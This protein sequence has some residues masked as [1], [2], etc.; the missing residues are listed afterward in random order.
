M[1]NCRKV[2]ETLSDYLDDDVALATRRDLETHLAECRTCT[3]IYD[4]AKRTLRIVTDVGSFEIPAEVSE[5]LLQATMAGI[6]S[7]SGDGAG[8]NPPL[9]GTPGRRPS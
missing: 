6:E 7:S 4:T 2:L 3:V 1:I 9:P 5:R 8:Q